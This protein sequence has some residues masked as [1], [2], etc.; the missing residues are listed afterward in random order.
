MQGWGFICGSAGAALGISQPFHLTWLSLKTIW[1]NLNPSK[2]SKICSVKR[3]E[4]LTRFLT[5]NNFLNNT[6]W[7]DWDTFVLLLAHQNLEVQSCAGKLFKP[8]QNQ[9]NV[10]I[11]QVQNRIQKPPRSS[12]SIMS[13]WKPVEVNGSNSDPNFVNQIALTVS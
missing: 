13:Y 7:T 1:D 9:Q 5:N 6:F 3:R 11:K 4:F 10:K 12:V 8:P 2:S